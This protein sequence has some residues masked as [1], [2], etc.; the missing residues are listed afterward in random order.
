MK[1]L[2]TLCAAL[3]LATFATTAVLWSGAYN[4]AADEP[5]WPFTH[6]LIGYARERSIAARMAQMRVPDLAEPA[7]I[8]SGAGNYNAMCVSCHLKP[9]LAATELSAA[10]YPRPLDLSRTRSSNPARDFWIVKHGIKM[11]GMPA[12]G[13]S[14]N[15]GYLWGMVA[16]LQQLPQLT[17]AAYAELAETSAGHAHGGGESSSPHMHDEP[18]TATP[19]ADAAAPAQQHADEHKDEHAHEHVDH[20]EHT[21]APH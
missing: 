1:T 15:D 6:T 19:H 11:S 8:A 14:M 17:P 13:K 12:W 21:A 10:L 16:F 20:R 9:G 18:V 3:V 7:R 4:I 2:I 5:H